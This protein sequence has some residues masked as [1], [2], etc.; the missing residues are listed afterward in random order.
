MESI[1]GHIF[2]LKQICRVC[3]NLAEIAEKQIRPY[4]KTL[5]KE[6]LEKLYGI[7]IDTDIEE[8]HPKAIW[9][10][11]KKMKQKCDIGVQI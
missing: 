3:G 7:Y 1:Q 10:V 6:E 4:D 5:F 8:V 9:V 11:S 2:K